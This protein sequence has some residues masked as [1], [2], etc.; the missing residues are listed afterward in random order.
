MN[1]INPEKVKFLNRNFLFVYVPNQYLFV[2]MPQWYSENIRSER[3]LIGAGQ[4]SK[5][6][7]SVNAITVQNLAL[8]QKTDK[9][10]VKFR[11][12]CKIIIYVK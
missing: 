9:H 5:Y 11:K 6:L 8:N 12:Y 4:L 10:T 7:G 3:F 2:L 1:C